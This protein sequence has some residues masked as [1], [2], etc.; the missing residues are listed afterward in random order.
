MLTP[1]WLRSLDELVPI[2]QRYV[3]I[4][5]SVAAETGAALCDLARD[6][7]SIPLAE[8]QERFF[9]SDGIHLT[10]D[11][12]QRIASYLVSCFGRYPTLQAVLSES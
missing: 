11:G 3:E 5:R 8:R 9:Y 12:D 2:H 10:P 6:F 4:V 1:R 7:E